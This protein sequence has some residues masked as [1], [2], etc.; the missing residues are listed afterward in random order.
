MINKVCASGMKATIIGAMSI[1]THS[2]NAVIT[3]GFESMSNAP[4]YVMNHRDG[5]P[6]F[7]N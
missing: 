1:Q 5:R 6:S 2:N 7:G 3:G 4:F